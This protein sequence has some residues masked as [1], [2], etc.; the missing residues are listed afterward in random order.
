[1]TVI[2]PVALTTRH[3]PG[4]PIDSTSALLRGNLI[5]FVRVQAR[6]GFCCGLRAE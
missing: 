6:F 4:A 2:C 3:D 5:V 1:M